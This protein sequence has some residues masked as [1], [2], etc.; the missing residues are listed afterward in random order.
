MQV[1]N[2]KPEVETRLSSVYVW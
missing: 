1:Q 2:S